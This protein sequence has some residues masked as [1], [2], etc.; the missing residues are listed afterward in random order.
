MAR[1]WRRCARLSSSTASASSPMCSPDEAAPRT[2]ATS[3]TYGK[4]HSYLQSGADLQTRQPPKSENRRIS[5]NKI[6]LTWTFRPTVISG[7]PS[8]EG[9]DG[10]RTPG[11]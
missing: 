3:P 7:Q 10:V 2:G 6:T 8:H 1:N 4:S 5:E 9:P 11:L